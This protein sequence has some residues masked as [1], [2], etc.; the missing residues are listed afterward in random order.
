MTPGNCKTDLEG[1][2][3]TRTA[4]EGSDTIEWLIVEVPFKFDQEVNGKYFENR[5]ISDLFYRDQS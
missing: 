1:D 4:D 5:K 2:T 3:A